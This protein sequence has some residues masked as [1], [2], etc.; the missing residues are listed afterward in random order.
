MEIFEGPLD[1]LL[2]LIRKNDLNISDIPIMPVLD[3]YNEYIDM[4][5]ELDID[6][7]GEF[8]LMAS[9]LAHIKSRLLLHRDDEIAEEEDPRADLM[10]RLLEYQRYKLAARWLTGR[11]LLGRDVFKRPKVPPPEAPAEGEDW[12]TVEPFTLLKAFHEVLKKVPKDKA[13]FIT[14]E[15]VSVTDRIYE[16]LDHLKGAE[17]LPFE[18][19]FTAGVTREE[20][21][22]TFLALLEMA[23]LKMIRIYQLEALGPIRVARNMEVGEVATAV[24]IEEE[25][26]YQ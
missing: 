24:K 2:Y 12:L 18:D 14:A 26:T 9:E 10:A 16:I 1:L 11:R 21:V 3:Q 6:V 19:L 22:V 4:M 20:L 23:R 7:A 5:H 17:S 8:I 15:R 25:K 13:H